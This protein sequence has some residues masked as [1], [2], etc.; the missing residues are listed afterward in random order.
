MGALKVKEKNSG[1]IPSGGEFPLKK[2]GMPRAFKLRST[3]Q[4]ETVFGY[5][6]SKSSQQLS[7][8]A[9]QNGL[10]FSRIGLSVSKRVSGC[11]VTR[12]LIRRRLREAFRKLRLRLPVGFDFVVSA[13]SAKLPVGA[14]LD[15]MVF[16]LMGHA[17]DKA[18]RKAYGPGLESG[19]P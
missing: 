11:G 10:S 13:R 15:S 19:P 14:R 12:N 1:A 9:I 16:D 2:Y 4:F 17:A 6:C 7:V 5:R 8:H 3:S 18:M